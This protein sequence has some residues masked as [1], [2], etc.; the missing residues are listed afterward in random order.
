[1]KAKRSALE[2]IVRKSSALNDPQQEYPQKCPQSGILEGYRKGGISRR[3]IGSL[4]VA[5]RCQ[6]EGDCAT[7]VRGRG[8]SLQAILR[9]RDCA[10]GRSVWQWEREYGGQLNVFEL[11][12]KLITDYSSYIRNF[13]RI[14]DTRVDARVKSC[15]DQGVL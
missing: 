5:Y 6:A 11:R 10:R 14:R 7:S 4:R 2:A 1:M 9:A 8:G 13:I 15:L 12:E 3:R